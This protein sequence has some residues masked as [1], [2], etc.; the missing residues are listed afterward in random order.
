MAPRPATTWWIPALEWNREEYLYHRTPLEQVAVAQTPLTLRTDDGLHLSI[1]EAALV[2]YAGMNLAKGEG[3]R[4]RASLT[5][6]SV[7]NVVRRAPFATPS[8]PMA[9]RRQR[10]RMHSDSSA[11]PT[12]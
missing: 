8:R 10:Q 5:P 4:L 12:P 2:D 7:A 11:H 9:M 6:G 3:G 1:H